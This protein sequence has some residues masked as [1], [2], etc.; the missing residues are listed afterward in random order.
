MNKLTISFEI[1]WTDETTYNSI[2]KKLNEAIQAGL[3]APDWWSENTSFYVVQTKENSSSFAVRVW[4]AAGMRKSKD[5]LLVINTNGEGG[6]AIGNFKD[7]TLF[8]LL[9]FVKKLE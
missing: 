4:N 6:A 1:E 9:P 7:Q 8:S 2:Y 5:R 3:K